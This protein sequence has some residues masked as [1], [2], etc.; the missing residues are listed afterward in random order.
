VTAAPEK[1]ADWLAVNPPPDDAFTQTLAG[2]AERVGNASAFQAAVREFLDEFALRPPRLRASAIASEPAPTGDL[3][4]D[5]YL[6][7]L[8]EN[9]AVHHGLSRPPWAV[10]SGRFLERFW[11]VSDVPGF[12][13]VSLATSPAAFRRRGIF[14]GPGALDRV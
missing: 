4:Y 7:A 14:L 3:R 11:F 10:D 8:A 9:L 2:V 13:A 5:A 6:G 1:L 12:R